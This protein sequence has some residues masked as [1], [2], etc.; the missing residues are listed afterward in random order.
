MSM[1]KTGKGKEENKPD[2]SDNYIL[3]AGFPGRLHINYCPPEQ[4]INET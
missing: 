2:L 4:D 1:S 3:I